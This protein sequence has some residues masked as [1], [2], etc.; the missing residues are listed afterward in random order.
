MSTLFYKAKV[1]YGLHA[2]LLL[3]RLLRLVKEGVCAEVTRASI[4]SK[5]SQLQCRLRLEGICGICSCVTK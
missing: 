1:K 5:S 3:L 4:G 2:P